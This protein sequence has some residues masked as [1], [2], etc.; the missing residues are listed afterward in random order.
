MIPSACPL[1]AVNHA[2]VSDVLLKRVRDLPAGAA[3]ALT[4]VVEALGESG[5]RYEFDSGFESGL[6]VLVLGIEAGI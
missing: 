1:S 4:R 5:F 3:P 6:N 2:A